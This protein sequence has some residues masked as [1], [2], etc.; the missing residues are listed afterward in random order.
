MPTNNIDVESPEDFTRYYRHSYIGLREQPGSIA[1]V[2]KVYNADA[3]PVKV[4]KINLLT[5]DT[6]TPVHYTWDYVDQYGILGL[7]PLGMI[8]GE[9]TCGWWAYR[10]SRDTSR[11]YRPEKAH[12]I[13]FNG[14]L[15]KMQPA[16]VSSRIPFINSVFNPKYYELNEALALL[17]EGE[18]AGC[19]LSKELALYINPSC[20]YS[21]LAYKGHQIGYVVNPFEVK[22]LK[23][24]RIFYDS[25]VRALPIG[26]SV[27]LA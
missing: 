27:E 9:Y 14:H 11:G 1:Q 24:Y 10:T 2:F 16:Q 25:V 8:N 19:A 22:I 12:G 23:H 5:L 7:P 6:G 3:A 4:P 18:R 13:I 26:I 15:F 20:L 17:D 21:C